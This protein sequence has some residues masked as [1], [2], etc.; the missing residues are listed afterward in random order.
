MFPNEVE[1]V[2]VVVE[3]V[4]EEEEEEL[5]VV[6]EVLLVITPNVNSAIL[7]AYIREQSLGCE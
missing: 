5:V 2:A 4:E 3:L 6:E 1:V 7:C